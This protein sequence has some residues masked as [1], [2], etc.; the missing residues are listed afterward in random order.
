MM[1]DEPGPQ[2]FFLFDGLN[3]GL[4]LPRMP[5]WPAQKGYTFCAWVRLEVGPASSGGR[6]GGA[7]SGNRTI[8]VAEAPCLFS[9]CG[10]G[11]QGVAACFIPLR[12]KRGSVQRG[13]AAPAT[14][15]I[16]ETPQQY[17]LELRVGAGRKKTPAIVRF[18]GI[19]V[20]AG[21]WVFVA[22][23]HAASRWGQRGEA[24]VLV[25][26]SWRTSASPFPRFGD[27]GV[28]TA[29]IA[30]HCPRR[31]KAAGGNASDAGEGVGAKV[32]GRPVLCSLQ[33]QVRCCK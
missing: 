21:E 10:E 4:R 16:A 23:A 27:G 11:G 31:A 9:F 30:C 18:P 32:A 14:T 29:S 5:R 3:S 22:V 6:D 19:V 17:A 15:S 2:R 24:S 13:A 25:D 8:P 28:A 7:C 20:T 12:K 26:S 33:G 1:D